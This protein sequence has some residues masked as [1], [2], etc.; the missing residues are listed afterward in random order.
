MILIFITAPIA[1]LAVAALISVRRRRLHR[2]QNAMAD[3]ALTAVY[4][5]YQKEVREFTQVYTRHAPPEDQWLAEID[6]GLRIRDEPDA[7]RWPTVLQQSLVHILVFTVPV[8]IAIDSAILGLLAAATFHHGV[9]WGLLIPAWGLLGVLTQYKWQPPRWLT[10]LA[11]GRSVHVVI[12]G[13]LIG[14]VAA[15]V[16]SGGGWWALLI[17][18]VGLLFLHVRATDGRRPSPRWLTLLAG[19][20]PVQVVIGGALMGLVAAAVISGGGWW[21]LLVPAGSL[22]FLLAIFGDWPRDSLSLLAD[23]RP[24]QVVIAGALI[25]LVAAA[26]VSGGAWWA[27]LV[28]AFGLVQILVRFSS[29]SG[30]RTDEHDI[31][32]RDHLVN[33]RR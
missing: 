23:R 12:G 28:P 8:L 27:L 26:I 20:K 21:A 30:A 6:A 9:W 19:R 11:G 22:L 29:R 25:G 33:S 15:A 3:A 13:A 17:P 14:L 18:A 31:E 24:V 4:A 2:R 32:T 7:S 1:L 5:R 16:I 10:L